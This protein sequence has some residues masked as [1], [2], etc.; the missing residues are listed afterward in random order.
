MWPFCALEHN[1]NRIADHYGLA[2]LPAYTGGY[3]I[4]PSSPVPVIRHHP[5]K[6]LALCHWG[7][8]P[9]WAKEPVLK[10]I[11]A[12]AQTLTGKPC[13]RDAFRRRR[14]LVLANGYYEWRMEFKIFQVKTC[15]QTLCL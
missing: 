11:N 9:H 1:N 2:A 14:C 12:R 10:P 15:S 13:F 5:G 6:E 4:V 7:F 3:N 8:I